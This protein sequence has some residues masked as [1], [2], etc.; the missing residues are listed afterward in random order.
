MP[1]YTPD[2]VSVSPERHPQPTGMS[3]YRSKAWLANHHEFTDVDI[4]VFSI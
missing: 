3:P 2:S 4:S 1:H